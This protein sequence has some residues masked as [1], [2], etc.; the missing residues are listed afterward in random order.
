MINTTEQDDVRYYK[1][2]VKKRL[3]KKLGTV[4]GRK[5][6]K[7]A[8]AELRRTIKVKPSMLRKLVSFLVTDYHFHKAVKERG[9][10]NKKRGGLGTVRLGCSG[11][12]SS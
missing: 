2:F 6:Y 4:A 3:Y 1:K 7:G 11:K 12:L 9:E 8:Q 5:V 10:A